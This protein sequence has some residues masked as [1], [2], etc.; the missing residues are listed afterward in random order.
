MKGIRNRLKNSGS[1]ASSWS[2]YDFLYTTFPF[3]FM[4]DKVVDLIE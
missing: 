4:K 2:T 1:R 3:N